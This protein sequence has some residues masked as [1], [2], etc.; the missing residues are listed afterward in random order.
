ML[1]DPAH[2][3]KAD[4]RGEEHACKH[5]LNRFK[6]R[7]SMKTDIAL[8]AQTGSSRT[9]QTR[10]EPFAPRSDADDKTYSLFQPDILAADQYF[11]HTR[12]KNPLEP[13]KRLMLAVLRDAVECFQKYLFSKSAKGKVLFRDVEE[14]ILEENPDWLFSFVN[15][16]ELLGLDATYIRHG[17]MDWK[18]QALSG[19]GSAQIYHLNAHRRGRATVRTRARNTSALKVAGI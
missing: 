2:R 1:L 9:G 17:L 15:T 14:W 10:E 18:K 11:Q 3:D 6:G 7:T 13:E 19:K 4:L 16:C 8:D 12:R 5:S